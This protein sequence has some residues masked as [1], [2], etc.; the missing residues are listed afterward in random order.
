[1]LVDPVCWKDSDKSSSGWLK[2]NRELPPEYCH[3]E[4]FAV[5][6]ILPLSFWQVYDGCTPKCPFIPQPRYDDLYLLQ[7]ALFKKTL[8]KMLWV[9]NVSAFW[10]KCLRNVTILNYHFTHQ[11]ILCLKKEQRE[12]DFPVLICLY[13]KHSHWIAKW[14][15]VSL[16]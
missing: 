10:N 12:G 8:L 5:E 1:M 13:L 11:L 14:W 4:S 7:V 15:Y 16:N 2:K 6:L 3:D 9:W